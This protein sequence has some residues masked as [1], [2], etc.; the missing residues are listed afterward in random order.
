M[1][2][3]VMRGLLLLYLAFWVFLG[4]STEDIE[5][6]CHASMYTNIKQKLPRRWGDRE[7]EIWKY[8]PIYFVLILN[9]RI[10]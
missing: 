3:R 1:S 4:P 7:E 8:I 6:Q 2:F 5:Y 9:L 10:K